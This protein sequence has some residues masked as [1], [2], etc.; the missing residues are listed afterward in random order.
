VDPGDAGPNEFPHG[1]HGVQWL[2]E[3][4]ASVDHHRNVDRRRGIG[5][6]RDLLTHRQ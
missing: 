2:T 5:G 3:A 6:E 1:A 4:S